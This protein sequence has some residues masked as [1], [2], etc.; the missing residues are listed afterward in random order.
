MALLAK[1]HGRRAR[2]KFGGG[3]NDECCHATAM[4]PVQ[5]IAC[6]TQKYPRW[7]SVGYVL[8][9]LQ[10]TAPVRVSG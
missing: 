10:R 5:T 2:G 8:K 6:I 9:H 1:A 3:E 4:L 7:M